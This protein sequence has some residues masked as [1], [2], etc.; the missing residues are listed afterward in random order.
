MERCIHIKANGERCN[1]PAK[2]GS[3][4]CVWHGDGKKP[5]EFQAK[6]SGGAK[7]DGQKRR[8][9]DIV[10]NLSHMKVFIE[11]QIKECKAGNLAPNQLNS[12]INACNA[13]VKIHEI[14]EV[15]KALVQ[16]KSDVLRARLREQLPEGADYIYQQENVN[17]VEY[18]AVVVDAEYQSKAN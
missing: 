15:Q 11:K 4:L 9:L 12:I 18:E 3:T 16:M 1:T 2:R 5:W 10:G 17:P 6:R 8:K 14:E 13:V 7:V